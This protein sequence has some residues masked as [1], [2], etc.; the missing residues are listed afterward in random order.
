MPARF[1]LLLV[2]AGCG[3]GAASQCVYDNATGPISFKYSPGNI[4]PS[5]TEFPHGLRYVQNTAECCALCQKYKN[6]TFWTRTPGPKCYDKEA[7]CCYLKTAVAWAGRAP[8]TP[9]VISGSTKPLPVLPGKVLCSDGTNC[10]GTNSWTKWQDN[11]LPNATSSNP[12]TMPYPRSKDL[13]GWE[14]KSGCNPGYGGGKAYGYKDSSADTWLS[15]WAADGNLY[16]VWGDGHVQ[17]DITGTVAIG[18]SCGKPPLF[19]VY[20]G[21]AAIVGDD[22]FNLTV[23]KVKGYSPEGYSAYP[24]GVRTPSGSL[25]YKGTWFYGTYYTP[26]YGY[27]P[28]PQ[29]PLVGGLLGPLASFRTSTD[30]GETWTE[31]LLNATGPADNLLGEVGDPI[32]K[33]D[34]PARITFGNPHFVDFG[35]EL[36]HSPDGKAYIV[37]HG[38]TAPSSTEMWMIGDQVYLARVAPTVAAINDKSQWEF[39]A[40]GHGAAAKWVA[41]DVRQATPLVEFTNHTG[42]TTMTYFPGLKKY[43]ITICSA[44]DYPKM[45]GGHFDTWILE[46]DD[47]TGPWALVEYMKSFGPQAYLANFVSKFTAE[48]ADTTARTFESMMMYSANY[49]SGGGAPNPPNSGY[50]MNLQQSRFDLSESFAARLEAAGM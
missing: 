47:I 26:A 8:G 23:T 42:G 46:S 31:P 22:P 18:N 2:V 16:T 48:K 29:G 6:C 12:G 4:F 49:D 1:L 36:E 13:V 35:Q 39:Y 5:T 28:Y 38:A 41:G 24:Y 45:D 40:G 30:L 7:S 34:L 50:H 11:S 33:P 44:H 25:F 17:D 43:V 20:H 3:S 14:F 9:G 27:G 19:K 37:A 21:Q 15:S 32:S 10:G